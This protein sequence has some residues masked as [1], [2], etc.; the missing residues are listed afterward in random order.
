M[1]WHQELSKPAQFNLSQVVD[2]VND[3]AE[4]LAG[5]LEN[6]TEKKSCHNRELNHLRQV[7]RYD[8]SQ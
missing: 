2:R 7:G 3:V 1:S 6:Y 8:I 5:R 4:C